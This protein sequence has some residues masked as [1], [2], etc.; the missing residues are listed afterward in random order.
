MGMNKS[1]QL[2]L[3]PEVRRTPR[4]L[5]TA[6]RLDDPVQ[7]QE[8]ETRSCSQSGSTFEEARQVKHSR[9]FNDIWSLVGANNQP[10]RSSDVSMDLDS[11]HASID[12]RH[13]SGVSSLSHLAM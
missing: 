6:L 9:S 11:R 4:L 8:M 3:T 10:R 13:T 2:L 1:L 12:S 5:P 7:V